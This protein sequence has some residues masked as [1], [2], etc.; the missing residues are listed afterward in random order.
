MR[1]DIEQLLTST[2]RASTSRHDPLPPAALELLERIKKDA[3]PHIASGRPRVPQ[4]TFARRR[5]R[6]VTGGAAALLI[7]LLAGVFVVTQ[8]PVTAYAMTPPMLPVTAVDGEPGVILRDLAALR[9]QGSGSNAIDGNTIRLHEWSLSIAMDGEGKVTATSTVP[10]LVEDTLGSDGTL[11]RLATAAEPFPGQD[12]T[13]LAKPGTVLEESTFD[14]ESTRGPEMP[15]TAAAMGSF[16]DDRLHAQGI[17]SPSLVDYFTEVASLLRLRIVTPQQESALLFFLSE[18]RGLRVEGR[19]VD[20]VGR[21]GLLLTASDDP[22]GNIEQSLIVSEE[23]GVFLASETRYVGEYP[24]EREVP[25]PSVM[26]YVA[27]DRATS[28]SSDVPDDA[29]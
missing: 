8:Q 29:L 23:S 24:N 6:S 27:W 12:D 1:D 4:A 13:T 2:K 17:D 25:S 9:R 28:S 5:W 26:S 15:V 11:T 18:Q 20:R 16:I 22:S 21:S 7:L 19:V 10:M 3:P 14:N